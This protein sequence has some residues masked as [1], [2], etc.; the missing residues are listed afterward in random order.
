MKKFGLMLFL[1]LLFSLVFVHSVSA[2][3]KDIN[4]EDVNKMVED[5]IHDEANSIREELRSY[6][7]DAEKTINAQV[8]RMNRAAKFQLLGITSCIILALSIFELIR[9]RINS[10]TRRKEK[11]ERELQV[12]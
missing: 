10:N 8:D 11:L 12:K 7:A 1:L 9:F 6:R 2:E 3:D 5:V 4:A